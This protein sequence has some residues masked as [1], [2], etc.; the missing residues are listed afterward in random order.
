MWKP[1]KEDWYFIIPMFLAVLAF[2]RLDWPSLAAKLGMST[3]NLQL[4]I[5]YAL[6]TS[7]MLVAWRGWRLAKSR[8]TFGPAKEKVYR[9]TYT[10]KE[11]ETD[12]KVFEYCTFDNAT[13]MFRGTARAEFH[14]CVVKVPVRLMTD[15]KA[16]HSYLEIDAMLLAQ[17]GAM[18]R[19]TLGVD[20]HGNAVRIAPPIVKRKPDENK[21]PGT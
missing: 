20:E 14:E 6:A 9:Q 16:I 17:S 10:G 4:W 13:L 5:A 21:P 19:E 18:R 7:A 11:V 3:T 8:G 15:M 1:K 12:G 2:F